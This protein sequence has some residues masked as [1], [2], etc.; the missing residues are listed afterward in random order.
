[1]KNTQE[2]K[3]INGESLGWA[4]LDLIMLI[5]NIYG[6]IQSST[7]WGLLNLLF[8]FIFSYYFVKDLGETFK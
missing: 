1:M 3:K 7:L 2:S 6:Y 8:I 4:I 5:L